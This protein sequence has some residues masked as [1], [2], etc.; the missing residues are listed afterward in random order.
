VSTM[1]NVTAST[2]KI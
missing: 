1:M 2:G